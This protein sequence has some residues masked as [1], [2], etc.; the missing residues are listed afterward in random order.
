[1]DTLVGNPCP[2]LLKIPSFFFNGSLQK[3][4][5]LFLGERC[6]VAVGTNQA[7]LRYDV[8]VSVLLF[9]SREG[10]DMSCR[11]PKDFLTYPGKG[12]YTGLNEGTHMF[13][14]VSGVCIFGV[15]PFRDIF[16]DANFF[17][18]MKR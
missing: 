10:W 12:M 3:Q 6:L 1:M 18:G 2:S 11:Y 7:R 14:C 15:R 13:F 17:K 16:G 5:N 8:E 4:G 9:F